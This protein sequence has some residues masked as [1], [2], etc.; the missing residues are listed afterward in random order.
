MASHHAASPTE[1]RADLHRPLP[2]DLERV[3][4]LVAEDLVRDGATPRVGVAYS[5]GVDSAVLGALTARAVGQ[6]NTVLLLGVSPSLARRE[7]RLAHRQAEQLGLTVVEVATHELE[8]P[9]Y[10]ANPVD[11]CYFCKDELF[12]RLDARVVDELGLDVVAYGE[13]ADDALRPDRP[14]SRAAREHHVRHPLASA[15]ATKA[16]V[17]EIAAHLGLHAAAKPAS[18]CLSSRIPHGQEVTA[19]KLAAIDAAEDAVLA[20]GFSDCRVRHHGDSARIEVP[21]DEFGLLADHARSTH[22]LAEVRAAGFRHVTL[23]LA[24][25]QSGAFTLSLLTRRPEAL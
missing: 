21:T 24:G 3:A 7:R 25:I 10:S 22:L 4:A 15:G 6:D 20:A 2:A 5:G 23:D 19:E 16:L 17:R 13:N 18:P 11:R 9:F 1:A 14:G 12:T 8:N